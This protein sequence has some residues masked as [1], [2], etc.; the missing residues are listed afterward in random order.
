MF[1]RTYTYTVGLSADAPVKPS[2]GEVTA[3]DPYD[4]DN[5][6][7]L[8]VNINPTPSTKVMP[9]RVVLNLTSGKLLNDYSFLIK[10]EPHVRSSD[11]SFVTDPGLPLT[12]IPASSDPNSGVHTFVI[13]HSATGNVPS[14][15]FKIGV[16]INTTPS[17]SLEFP[18]L[19]K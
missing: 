8:N 9:A 6:H 10:S 15:I 1:L 13:K 3:I 12:I 19:V 18:V 4:S 2:V 16:N 11:I 17:Q 14:G 7:K 5:Q